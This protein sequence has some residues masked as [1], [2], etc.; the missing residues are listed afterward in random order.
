LD[1]LAQTT[2]RTKTFYVKEA[3]L[4]FLDEMEDVY[5]ALDRLENPKKRRSQ[6][7]LENNIGLK[8]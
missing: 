2:G 7:D 4:R 1:Q 3:I 8:C 5:Y 6:D